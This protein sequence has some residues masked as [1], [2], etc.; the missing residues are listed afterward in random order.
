[1]AAEPDFYLPPRRP[2]SPPEEEEIWRS[3]EDHKHPPSGGNPPHIISGYQSPASPVVPASGAAVIVPI[4]ISLIL[5]GAQ[6]TTAEPT[7]LILRPEGWWDIVVQW[8]PPIGSGPGLY[9]IHAIGAGAAP[10]QCAWNPTVIAAGTDF[11][12]SCT[13]P[14]L[15]Y[16]NNVQVIYLSQTSGADVPVGDVAVTAV[17]LTDRGF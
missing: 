11:S 17:R 10:L 14:A 2:N 1:M 13:L 4:V 7:G 5:G 9:R 6:D 15:S 3:V 12:L 8:L 16:N